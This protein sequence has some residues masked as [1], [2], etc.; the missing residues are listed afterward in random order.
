MKALY[1]ILGFLILHNLPSMAQNSK[2]VSAKLFYSLTQK[3]PNSLIIDV[4]PSKKFSQYRIHNA[5]PAPEKEDLKELV[6]L[7]PK[8]D[9]LFV[10]CEKD[11]R[12]KPAAELLDSLG[13]TNVFELKGG[14]I[15][16]RRNGLP[17]DEEVF[18]H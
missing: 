6:I 17:L 11:I 2:R 5:A 1:F 9:T 7:V 16:W 3:H 4:R 13:Y 8:N 15:S 14:L 12:T 10:Y 18:D